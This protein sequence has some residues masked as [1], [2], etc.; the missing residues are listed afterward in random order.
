[1]RRLPPW[2]HIVC[3]GSMLE[4]SSRAPAV[5]SLKIDAAGA[6]PRS[7]KGSPFGK[8]REY[9][10]SAST[11]PVWGSMAADLFEEVRAVD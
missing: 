6:T 9:D 4:P 3:S 5:T 7:A 10:A 11:L 8:A 1:M 2:K